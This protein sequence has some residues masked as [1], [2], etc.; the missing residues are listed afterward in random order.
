[1]GDGDYSEWSE[2]QPAALL[3]LSRGLLAM[4]TTWIRPRGTLQGNCQYLA[5]EMAANT[6]A[7]STTSQSVQPKGNNLSTGSDTWTW[8][9]LSS[10]TPYFNVIL[11]SMNA[12]FFVSGSS[13]RIT[14]ICRTACKFTKQHGIRW[15][16]ISS[17]RKVNEVAGE[18][19]L[20]TPQPFP[21]PKHAAR[22]QEN[23]RY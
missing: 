13:F 17:V 12:S 20:T 18:R 7:F 3:T 5:V 9:W 2:V 21:F 15:Q 22:C 14:Y 4:L 8:R 19:V 16:G 11:F 23:S 10:R 1:M 6:E